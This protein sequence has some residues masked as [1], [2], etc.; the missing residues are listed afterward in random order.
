MPDA[1]I[2]KFCWR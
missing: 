1:T 2:L